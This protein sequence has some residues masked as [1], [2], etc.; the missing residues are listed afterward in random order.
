MREH[1][2]LWKIA[3]YEFIYANSNLWKIL[4]E[5]NRHNFID[6]NNPDLIEIDQALI[7][8]SINKETRTGIFWKIWEL[9]N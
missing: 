2:N 4:Y 9:V 3:G 1:D 6:E 7:I 5:A 8:P